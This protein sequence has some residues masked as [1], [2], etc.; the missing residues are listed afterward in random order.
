MRRDPWDNLNLRI[1]QCRRCPRLASYIREVAR[2]K[3]R[4][5]QDQTYWGRPV[6]GFGDRSA[7]LLIIGLAPAAHGANRTGRMFTGDASGMFLAQALHRHGFANQPVSRSRDDGL[8]LNDVFLSAVVR[9]APPKNRPTL[10]EMEQCL[11]FLEEELRLLDRLRV[12]LTLG[13]I[14]THGYLKILKHQGW[15]LSRAPYPFGHHR[16][17][18]I[19]PQLPVLVT[20]YHP[21]RQNTQTGRLTPEMF[22]EVF[23]TVRRLLDEEG[24]SG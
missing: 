14:A 3:R 6:P 5:Y 20:S 17:Y 1:V 23:R 8:V 21:S 18:R 10:Q 22:D 15:I 7:R 4:A 24:V 13:A 11:P 16:V 9:C 2:T 19:H 12:V